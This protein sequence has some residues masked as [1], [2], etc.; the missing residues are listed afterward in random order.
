MI[1]AMKNSEDTKRQKQKS[2]FY[3]DVVLEGKGWRC[4]FFQDC[5][6]IVHMSTLQSSIGSL[7]VAGK[8]TLFSPVVVDS[9][10]SVGRVSPPHQGGRAQWGEDDQGPGPACPQPRSG[11]DDPEHCA[12]GLEE[13]H[14]SPGASGLQGEERE[15]T[16]PRGLS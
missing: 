7:I 3:W 4:I 9:R 1:P 6:I 14:V 2:K 12:R 13:T 10:Q 5:F 15:R 11:R 16:E 8:G